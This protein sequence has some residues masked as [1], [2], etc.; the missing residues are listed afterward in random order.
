MGECLLWG[1]SKSNCIV[2]VV[3]GM[4]GGEVVKKFEHDLRLLYG[5]LPAD[6]KILVFCWLKR[7]RRVLEGS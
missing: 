6:F 5:Y 4:F 2:K 7:W 3:G 1:N